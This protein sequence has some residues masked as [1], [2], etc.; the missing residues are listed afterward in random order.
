MKDEADL[1]A[2]AAREIKSL[3]SQNQLM[4]ARLEMFDSMM[5][6]LHTEPA[7]KSQ[8]MAPDLVWEIE[9][10]LEKKPATVSN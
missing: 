3:R 8:G 7:R 2:E 4:S 1:L 6:V 5:T 10:F 9:K